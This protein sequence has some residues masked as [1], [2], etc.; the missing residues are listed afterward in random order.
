MSLHAP[1]KKHANSTMKWGVLNS[2]Q[3]NLLFIK[4]RIT[5]DENI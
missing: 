1:L 3:D 5:S 2:S 4:P